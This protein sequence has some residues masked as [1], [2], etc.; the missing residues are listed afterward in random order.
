M[1]NEVTVFNRE[2]EENL[3]PMFDP[4]RMIAKSF[5][6]EAG[7]KT[8][9]VPTAGVYAY[10]HINLDGSGVTYPVE[11]I[12]RTDTEKTFNLHNHEFKPV[13]LQDYDEFVTN[14]D[15]RQSILKDITGLLGAYAIRT[16]FGGFWS[17][18]AAYEYATT[19]SDTYTNR[20][21]DVVKNLTVA[22][23]ANVAKT[24][25]LQKV[26]R[27]GERY[28]VLD[29]EMYAGLVASLTV[30]G[31][32]STV[33]Q[34][35]QSGMIPNLHGF[36]VVQLAEVGVATASNAALRTPLTQGD[37]ATDCNFGFALHKNFV[38][39]GDSGVRLFLSENDPGYYGTVLSGSFYAGGSYLRENPIGCVTVFEKLN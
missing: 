33:T 24:L 12:A 3:F 22:D 7:A 5:S 39:F 36:K 25:D 2:I 19:G 4:I 35:F 34:A 28:L 32:T 26:P 37:A 30:E 1:A 17:G 14:Y 23:V 11:A 38:G 13:V 16:I 20:W 6:A 15:Y 9:S 29:P 8:I 21:G 27:D 31:Y 10:S 18:T